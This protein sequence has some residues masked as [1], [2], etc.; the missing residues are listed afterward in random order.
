M[1]DHQ[2]KKPKNRWLALA[3]ISL[4]SFLACLDFTIVNTAL[5]AIQ[6]SLHATMDQLQW[7]INLFLLAQCTFMV[8]AGRLA[9][10]YGRRLVLFIGMAGLGRLDLSRY[11]IDYNHV[12]FHKD[13]Q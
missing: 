2:V 3:G 11:K 6:S 1:M 7:V 4:T 12:V 13:L 9:D 5:P 10:L 8:T